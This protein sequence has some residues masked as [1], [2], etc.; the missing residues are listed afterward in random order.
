MPADL[1]NGLAPDAVAQVRA[2]SRRICVTAG[3]HL[4]SLGA[5]ADSLF[6][7]ERGRIVLSL[8]IQVAGRT[9]DVLVEERS[10]GQTLGWSAL[11]PP[12]R[13]TLDAR[14]PVEAVVLALPRELL[15]DYFAAHPDVG[16]AIVRNLAAVMGHRLQLFQTMWARAMQRVVE[17]HA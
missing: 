9:E 11:I 13:F 17:L 15:M 10:P 6:L 8:P 5:P 14:A 16:L 1:L 4:F 3:A 12:H 7:V 2:L